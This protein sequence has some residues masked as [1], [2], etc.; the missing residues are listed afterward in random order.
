[1]RLLSPPEQA[2]K[3]GLLLLYFD[4]E[5]LPNVK[6][7]EAN[8]LCRREVPNEIEHKLLR[9]LASQQDVRLAAS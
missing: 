9:E 6:L 8:I 7:V 4:G 5:T 3:Q 2:L 1:V